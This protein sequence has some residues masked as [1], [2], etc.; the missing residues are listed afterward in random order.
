MASW[1]WFCRGEGIR[2][3]K[4]ALC[5]DYNET[6]MKITVFRVSI[7]LLMIG[8]ISIILENVFYQYVDDNGVLH[9][10]F[11]MPLGVIALLSGGIGLLIVLVK[12]I[13]SAIK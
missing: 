10:S 1:R 6:N 5:A 4:D 2:L 3:A 7:I 9:E 13:W 8:V 11:F 12:A